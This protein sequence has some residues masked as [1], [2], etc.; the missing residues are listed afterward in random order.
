MFRQSRPKTRRRNLINHN[1]DDR[2]I[3]EQVKQGYSLTALLSLCTIS[4]AAVVIISSFE[5]ESC[6]GIGGVR[7]PLP[8]HWG[9]GCC[10]K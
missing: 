8:V 3:V 6:E 10:G 7:A 4:Y 5:T 9:D 1:Y 2:I